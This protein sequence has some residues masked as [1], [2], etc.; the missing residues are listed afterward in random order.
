MSGSLATSSTRNPGGMKN[1]FNASSG[2]STGDSLETFC[3]PG[4]QRRLTGEL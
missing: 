1:D 2:E 3:T 4:G